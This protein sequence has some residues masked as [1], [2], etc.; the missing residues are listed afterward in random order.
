M[1]S[2]TGILALFVIELSPIFFKKMAGLLQDN[3][4]LSSALIRAKQ[5]FLSLVSS[6]P[7]VPWV[8][9]TAVERS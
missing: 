7:A 8:P 1:V 3:R 9:E 5:M 6:P 4:A 2:S